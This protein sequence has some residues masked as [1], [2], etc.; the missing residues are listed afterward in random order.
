MAS[1]PR[2]TRSAEALNDETKRKKGR[3]PKSRAKRQVEPERYT[4]RSPDKKAVAKSRQ[5]LRRG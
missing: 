3:R 4:A 5:W 1:G 2:S